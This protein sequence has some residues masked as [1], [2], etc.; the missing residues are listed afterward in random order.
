ME[1]EHESLDGEA[2]FKIIQQAP[3]VDEV[4][5]Q[6][7]KRDQGNPGSR[8]LGVSYDGSGHFLEMHIM[9]TSHLF[10]RPF[11]FEL[12]RS[13]HP[14]QRGTVP[15]AF[16]T[17]PQGQ[18]LEAWRILLHAPQDRALHGQGRRVAQQGPSCIR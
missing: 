11:E 16:K 13:V 1:L 5:W 4:Q 3:G 12:T 8:A 14:K 7:A 17:A 2:F 6:T 18:L 10:E 15:M 9:V